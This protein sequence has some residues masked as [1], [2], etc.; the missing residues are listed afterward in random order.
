MSRPPRRDR[1][2]SAARRFCSPAARR[3]A[4]NAVISTAAASFLRNDIEVVGIKHGYSQLVNYAPSNPLVE[5]RDYVMLD[6]KMLRRTRN[7]QGILIGTA[8]DQPGQAS[9]RTRRTSTIPSSVTPLKTVYDALRSIGVDALISIGGDD[10]LKTANKFKLFQE[11]LPPDAHRI[12]VVHLPKTI[13]NDY[14]GIDFTFGYFTAVDILAGEDPQPAGR[15]RGQPQLLPRRDDGPQ[16]R[17]AGLRRRDRRRGEPGDQRRGHCRARIARP[18]KS[19]DPTTGEKTT[20]DVMNV[21]EVVTRIVATMTA[22]ETRRQGVRRDRAGRR[23]GRVPAQQATS[24]ASAATITATSPSPPSTLHD[25]F[26]DLDRARNTQ[27]QTGKKR[28]V[29]ACSSATKPAA[30]SRTRS[31]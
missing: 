2:T 28:K 17:L 14:R 31:T 6:H 21:D 24:K 22:R 3:P 20:R 18:K 12:P 7:S 23:P 13:D 8:R 26:A 5:G 19:I 29:T 27:R 15:R 10:T 11:R 4:A 1:T 30:P 16:R 25:I 9:S